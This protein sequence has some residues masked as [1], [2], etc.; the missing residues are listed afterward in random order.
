MCVCLS[1]LHK[2]I[3]KMLY[4]WF[5]WS[6][7][8]LGLFIFFWILGSPRLWVASFLAYQRFSF[9]RK[10][11]V[12]GNCC[13][14]IGRKYLMPLNPEQQVKT[15]PFMSFSNRIWGS[16]VWQNISLTTWRL[17]SWPDQPPGVIVKG[18]KSS[19]S[20]ELQNQ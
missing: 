20:E 4:W 2:F 6:K 10:F 13:P 9:T 8:G 16:L 12:S 19:L 15:S 1:V 3:F 18:P 14:P 7:R 5:W 17:H 11:Q